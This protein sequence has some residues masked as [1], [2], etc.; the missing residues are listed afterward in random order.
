MKKVI[1]SILGI[2][3]F[4]IV[5]S[6]IYIAP[7]PMSISQKVG[8]TETYSIQI[9]NTYTYNILDLD[10][11]DL[12]DMGFS[13][14]DNSVN[15]NSS[16]NVTLTI[17]PDEDFNGIINQSVGFSFYANIPTEVTT[18]YIQIN[19]DGFDPAYLNMRVGDTVIFQNKDT[20][21]H[22]LYSNQFNENIQPNSNYSYTPQAEME[23]S[24]K[25]SNWDEYTNFNAILN[26][27]SR[28]SQEKVHNPL[29][30]I[31]WNLD[32]D[33]YLNPTT[34]N[35]ELL[36]NNLTAS[37]VSS[38]DGL[39]KITNN[40]TYNAKNIFL[41]SSDW[42]LFNKNNFNLDA[43]SQ[44]YVTYTV[45]PIIN[46]TEQ[47]NKSY[48]IPI[49]ITGNNIN[50][51]TKDV[52]VFVSYYEI[53]G[54][55][56][57]DEGTLYYLQNV[58]CPKHPCSIFCNPESEE[59]QLNSNSSTKYNSSVQVNVTGEDWKEMKRSQ[60]EIATDLERNSNTLTLQGDIINSNL[61]FI[62]ESISKIWTKLEEM[63]EEHET[64]VLVIWIVGFFLLM[65]ALS[66]ILF[67]RYRRIK[68]RQSY[69]ES[70]FEYRQ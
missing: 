61:P 30:D 29:L 63:D 6:Q 43:G 34:I 58:Y 25:D 47:T 20:I 70:P 8:T 53:A 64:T 66:G 17:A 24:Y 55:F 49:T 18:Y 57:S 19:D 44:T 7:N 65:F 37:P 39:I 4:G 16:K 41:S 45:Y 9:N 2:L 21:V 51:Q 54:G 33:F 35:F 40:G 23:L 59:C 48:T 52:N 68:R 14:S 10:F 1:L 15:A 27:I 36:D 50:N 26:V 13:F 22:N 32:I 3:V 60:Q 28:T 11:G 42:I 67:Y 38:T 56:D 62:N 46:S 69:T 31:K 5:S 12:E